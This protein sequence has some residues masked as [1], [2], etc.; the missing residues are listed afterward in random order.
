MRLGL[1]EVKLT[2]LHVLSNF[3]FEACPETQV[4]PLQVSPAA[5]PGVGV[6]TQFSTL[7]LTCYYS[8]CSLYGGLGLTM[9]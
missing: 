4:S 9:L 1:L 3:R 2:L 5:A 8:Y 7:E 6:L